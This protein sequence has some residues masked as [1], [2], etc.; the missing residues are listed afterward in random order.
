[1]KTLSLKRIPLTLI[2]GLAA[3]AAILIA[4]RATDKTDAPNPAT[5][6][7]ALR[8]EWNTAE[9]K[10]PNWKDP[11]LI[12]TN[13]GPW[14]NLPL[15]EVTRV[16]RDECKNCFDVLFPNDLQYRTRGESPD[17]RSIGINLQLKNV[18]LSEVFNAMNLI[19]E[20]EKAPWRWQL[21]LNGKRPTAVF[22]VLP[23]LL[24]G[25]Q[26]QP[27]PPR[28]EPKKERKVVFVG[29]LIGAA[30]SG[31]M[32]MGRITDTIYELYQMV[33]RPSQRDAFQKLLTAHDQ[34]QL[35]VITGTPEE[36]QFV[37][38]TL[39]ALKQKMAL[40]WRNKAQQSPKMPKPNSEATKTP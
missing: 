17:V 16:L 35:L 33:Y 2:L 3:V 31:G 1:M 6:S 21:V 7:P 11:D 29:D 25:A 8:T 37:E 15:V 34:A 30:E 26:P 24:P 22:R 27:Q 23:E 10:D 9:W 36:V 5:A 18:T 28:E 40:D 14:D 32:T 12:L 20:T 39:S 13:V 19:F 38:D 4:A